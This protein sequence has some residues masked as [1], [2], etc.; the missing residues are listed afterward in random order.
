MKGFKEVITITTIEHRVIDKIA[1]PSE[2]C[3][4]NGKFWYYDDIIILEH[5][6]ETELDNYK[7]FDFV[8]DNDSDIP[9][10]IEKVREILIKLELI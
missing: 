6:S 2:R 1:K 4:I 5:K 3:M 10:L 7:D 9:S 8:I